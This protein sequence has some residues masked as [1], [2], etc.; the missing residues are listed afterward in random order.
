MGLLVN[1]PVTAFD[2]ATAADLLLSQGERPA[3]ES[4]RKVLGRGSPATINAH[5]KEYYKSLPARLTLPPQIASAA[6]ALL[7]SIRNVGHDEIE[8]AKSAARQEVHEM[9]LML[10]AERSSAAAQRLA[11]IQAVEDFTAQS[12]QQAAQITQ[13]AEKLAVSQ[14]EAKQLS[15]QVAVATA[16]LQAEKRL[17]ENDLEIASDR[18]RRAEQAAKSHID[19]LEAR[20]AEQA[21]QVQRL[22]IIIQQAEAKLEQTN[23]AYQQKLEDAQAANE[24][25]KAQLGETTRSLV[26]AME[27]VE[28]ERASVA[29]L[30][31]A[32][33]TEVERLTV[34]IDELIS[35]N[36][37]T[38]ERLQATVLTHETL[39]NEASQLA[40]KAALYEG[41]ASVL[42]E[43]MDR[44]TA[45][46]SA[47]SM[48]PTA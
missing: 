41:R 5:L 6:I 26:S 43:Q 47:R 31:T 10:E 1:N 8:D 7:E 33:H 11:H 22:E 45:E 37:I 40:I 3:I 19:A 32:H 14:L 21:A 30:M 29:A 35:K 9:S 48:D 13:L 12:D 34:R 18:L 2:V 25:V 46:K 15:E 38:E 42:A 44:L 27:H 16:N 24:A 23:L 39:R 28:I 17:R 4:V 36:Q 20:L